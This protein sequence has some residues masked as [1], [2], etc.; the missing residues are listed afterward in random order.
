MLKFTINFDANECA[1]QFWNG[2]LDWIQRKS[3]KVNCHG[4]IKS[5]RASYYLMGALRRFNRATVTSPGGDNLVVDQ[6][7]N[8]L[9]D[10]KHL[11]QQSLKLM[12]LSI[13]M[14]LKC[15]IGARIALDTVSVGATINIILAA[16][17]AKGQTILENA[18]REPEIIDIATFLNNMGANIVGLETDTIRIGTCLK[19]RNTHTVIPDRISWYLYE[20]GCCFW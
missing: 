17:R 3:R 16:V 15:L 12:T 10:L 5:L 19:A 8:I 9:K 20:Y 6:L 1:F 18:A 14:P 13:L 2:N 4:A 11:V 7:I